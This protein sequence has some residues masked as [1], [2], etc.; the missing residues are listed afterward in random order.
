MVDSPTIRTSS[1]FSAGGRSATFQMMASGSLTAT[2]F[3]DA[4]ARSVIAKMLD[5][6]VPSGW[7]L[8][9]P[10]SIIDYALQ[11]WTANGDVTITGSANGYVVRQ[12]PTESLPM[13]LR[14]LNSHAAFE[15]IQDVARGSTVELRTAPM[16]APWLPLNADHISVVVVPAVP[17][18]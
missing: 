13:R 9:A 5:G 6:E 4:D 10:A 15:V 14:G 12:V 17:T 7:R 11:A 18:N 3:A 16:S 2:A 1:D 8:I